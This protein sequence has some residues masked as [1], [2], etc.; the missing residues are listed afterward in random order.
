MNIKSILKLG[1]LGLYGAAIGAASLAVT[2]VVD[3]A[4]AAAHGERSQE[5][6]LRMRSIHGTT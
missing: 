6:F 3:V 1:V 4:P 5:P 2:L